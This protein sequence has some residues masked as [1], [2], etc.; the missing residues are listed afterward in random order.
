M[1]N[2]AELNKIKNRR[3]LNL[4][5]SFSRQPPPD[6]EFETN[7]NLRDK[8]RSH[9]S[10]EQ[11]TEDYVDALPPTNHTHNVL[12]DALKKHVRSSEFEG[13]HKKVAG[14]KAKL[15]QNR[16]NKMFEEKSVGKSVGKT[17]NIST[18]NNTLG[19]LEE[20]KKQYSSEEKSYGIISETIKKLKSI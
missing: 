3:K 6:C 4:G 10:G 12:K 13:R 19:V 7:R 15:F 2:E 18:H 11:L 5:E 20:L 9:Q 17:S 8:F 1:F 14:K 16:L